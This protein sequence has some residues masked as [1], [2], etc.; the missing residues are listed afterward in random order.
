M[1]R[2]ELGV[3]EEVCL[4]ASVQVPE[5]VRREHAEEDVSA[6]PSLRAVVDG[7]DQQVDG[8]HRAEHLLD[9]GQSLVDPHEVDGFGLLLVAQRAADGIEAIQFGFL[10]DALLVSVKDEVARADVQNEVLGLLLAVHE[11]PR[12]QGDLVRVFDASGLDAGLERTKVLL[13][14][15][16]ECL[17]LA[18]AL[19]GE[20]GV[21]TDHQAL[22]GEVGGFDLHQV[23][24]VEDLE[25]DRPLIADPLELLGGDGRDPVH[26]P[27][28][29]KGLDLGSL[30]H[31]PVAHEDQVRQ[32]ESLLDL[33]DLRQ[34]GA[35]VGGVPFE[36]L[37]GDGAPV[38][39]GQHAVD[40]LG[41][42]PAVVPAVAMGRQRAV[43]TDDEAGG[44]V[45]EHQ[46]SALQMS[47]GEALL[48]AGLLLSDPVHRLV[49]V[50]LIGVL[51]PQQL[52]QRG[53]R[54]PT[55]Q[56]QLGAGAQDPRRDHPEHEASSPA[57]TRSDELGQAQVAHDAHHERGGAMVA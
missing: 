36:D 10:V 45:V 17:A 13:G 19:C 42:I 27:H 25:L 39:V 22:P 54:P 21:A 53:G 3:G 48:D 29:S 49:E 55:C 40:D 5:D 43:P 32:A 34:D 8:L 38:R 50:V 44:D 14:G 31:A 9:L 18:A 6:D 15:L 7:P 4:Q 51:D 30:E 57:G 52:R 26:T 35:A 28:G 46:A 24:L 2:P 33:L 56:G 11:A 1:K 37:D 12:T 47:R 41:A 23:A 20:R 16:Q